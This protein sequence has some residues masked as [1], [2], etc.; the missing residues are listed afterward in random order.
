MKRQLVYVIIATATLLFGTVQMG[1]AA[2]SG[3]RWQGH[4]AG[5]GRGAWHGDVRGHTGA[6]PRADWH[7]G[8]RRPGIAPH[9]PFVHDRFFHD[10]FRGH[11]GIGGSVVIGPGFWWGDPWWWGPSYPYPY[12]VAPPVVVPEAP[13]VYVEP[14]APAQQYWYYCPN[15]PGYY[16]YIKECP[17][18]WMTVVPPTTAPQAAPSP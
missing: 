5:G 8:F 4:G 14:E 2:G 1:L 7:G 9:R 18:G 11:G 3:S 10:R 6:A 15:P 13:P 17:P 16:P 12:Y